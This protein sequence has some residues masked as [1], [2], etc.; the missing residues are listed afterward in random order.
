[1]G[2]S[3]RK[4]NYF[5]FKIPLFAVE[6][7]WV[8]YLDI[9]FQY[10]D[11]LFSSDGS[12]YIQLLPRNEGEDAGDFLHIAKVPA[13]VSE[14]K[15]FTGLCNSS[16][17][18]VDQPHDFPFLWAALESATSESATSESIWKNQPFT[19]WTKWN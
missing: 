11:P 15:H 12:F 5:L 14:I 1:M 4:S 13:T 18:A 16:M 9:V 17:I 3:R 7:D 8:N 10:N 19:E 2:Q 6:F